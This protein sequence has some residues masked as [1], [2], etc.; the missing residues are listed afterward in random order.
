MLKNHWE[1][2]ECNLC[3]SRDYKLLYKSNFNAELVDR[4]FSQYSVHADIVRCNNCSLIY[5]S[6]RETVAVINK[7]LM[8]ETYPIK[9]L[10]VEE[11][12]KFFKL[13]IK[14]MKENIPVKG[15][16]LD[17]GC[18]IGDFLDLM[19][20]E[21]LDVFG[22]EPSAYA[23]ERA[24]EYYGLKVVNGVV[25]NALEGFED[26]FFDIVTL[27]DVIEHLPDPCGAL[28]GINR[29][30][31]KDGYICIATHNIDSL[32]S[33]I[34]KSLYPHLM[35]QHLYHFSDKTLKAVLDKSGFKV[36]KSEI[37]N[38]MWSVKYLI[39]LLKEFFPTNKFI[40]KISDNLT[41]ISGFLHLQNLMLVLPMYNDMRVY[42]KKQP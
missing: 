41:K 5:E 32:F 36:V 22:I 42:A 10:A 29:K 19:K 8:K 39:L 35:Y 6:P 28:S 38:K 37:F 20:K 18:N 13:H 14:S 33:K 25:D 7:R 31:K 2:A 16:L 21:G 1:E 27:W 4:Q 40:C 24:K 9:E 11:R 23:A 17:V 30:L 26:N 3:G 12:E 15:R 34:T